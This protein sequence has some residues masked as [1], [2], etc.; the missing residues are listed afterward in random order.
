MH[1]T[2]GESITP[3]IQKMGAI[4]DSDISSRGQP[5]SVIPA[6][7]EEHG[8]SFWPEQRE[9]NTRAEEPRGVT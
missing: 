6:Q 2:V 9:G 4:P 7:K 1:P 5:P 8:T 3:E